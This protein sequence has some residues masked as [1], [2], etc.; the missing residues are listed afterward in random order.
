MNLENGYLGWNKEYYINWKW[1]RLEFYK[2]YLLVEQVKLKKKIYTLLA[3][4][5]R[6]IRNRSLSCWTSEFFQEM[7]TSHYSSTIS[8]FI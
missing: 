7:P 1:Y 8:V 4:Q 3:E 6:F 5:M 2:K